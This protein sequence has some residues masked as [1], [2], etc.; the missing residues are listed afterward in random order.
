M[1]G[2]RDPKLLVQTAPFLHQGLTTPGL[3]GEV[4]LATLPVLAAAV[5]YFGAAALL[6]CAAAC[7]GAMSAE[8]LFT[9]GRRVASLMDGSA[10]LTG[11]LL[12]LT[13]PPALPLW[14][15]FLGGF[16]GIGLGKTIWGGL[17]SN[18]FNPALV[19]R[20]FLQ[21]AFPV[22]I[23]TWTAPVAGFGAALPDST[24]AAPFMHAEVDAISGAT[25]L[26]EMKFEHTGP[27]VG[28]LLVGNTS[29]SLG[30]TAALL[31]IAIG[32]I[33]AWRRT[34]DWRIPVALLATVA[35]LSGLLYALGPDRYPPPWYM[36]LSGGLLFGAVFMATD[37]ATS[38]IAPL[39]AW[40]FGAGIGVLVV[41]IRVFGGLPEGVMYAIL[42]M[43]ACT[44]LIERWCQ[45]TPLGRREAG[46]D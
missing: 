43:N 5:W 33:L 18:L 32:I 11:V 31:L 15:A 35:V 38:P 40:V 24:L 27:D 10:L 8:A 14:M 22:A 13:L 7:A 17:G 30:E 36:L 39:G 37:P 46:A 28:S 42:L 1:S 21:A 23:T 20:A 2:E 6:V 26:A 41:L 45:P 12:G 44:P 25:P 19:G 3:M 9:P 16:V 29:G 34:F 4:L